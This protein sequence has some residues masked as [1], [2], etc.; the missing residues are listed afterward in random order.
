MW[1]DVG[2]YELRNVI[3]G[4]ALWR[5]CHMKHHSKPLSSSHLTHCKKQLL[6]FVC[7][8]TCFCVTT[9]AGSSDCVPQALPTRSL[10]PAGMSRA[11]AQTVPIGLSSPS[12]LCLFKGTFSFRTVSDLQKCGSASPES[13]HPSPHPCPLLS[14]LHRHH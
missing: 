14:L 1:I 9:G 3:R 8:A 11:P 13:A 12:L 2:V 4:I 6:G 5:C 10:R 7:L